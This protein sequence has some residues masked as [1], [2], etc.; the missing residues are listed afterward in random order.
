[1]STELMLLDKSSLPA[2]QELRRSIQ[3]NFNGPVA[4]IIQT[5]LNILEFGISEPTFV[6]GHF[7][8]I[9][10]LYPEIAKYPPEEQMALR[11]VLHSAATQFVAAIH[12]NLLIKQKKARE[13]FDIFVQEVFDT[14][15]PI[16]ATG[17]QLLACPVGVSA[18][19]VGTAVQVRQSEND[20][21]SDLK[22]ELLSYVND[23]KKNW[24]EEKQEGKVGFFKKMWNCISSWN[25]KCSCENDMRRTV[26]KIYPKLERYV[27]L[28]G[29]SIKISEMARDYSDWLYE[30]DIA[31]ARAERIKG[32]GV[33]GAILGGIGCIVNGFIALVMA[34]WMC[35]SDNYFPRLVLS[36]ILIYPLIKWLFPQVRFVWRW[37]MGKLRRYK[38]M[39][40]AEKFDV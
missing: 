2:C 3:M 39:K 31:D 18:S 35:F 38:R 5:E 9:L 13:N 21:R 30:K 4:E 11:R 33:V 40:I 27:V 1:M 14:A 37:L 28:I 6:L 24:K 16:I 22:N 32:P 8:K 29:P 25:D 10:D 19:A 17:I 23:F 15:I 12:M 26:E 36:V 7:N 34:I 20:K